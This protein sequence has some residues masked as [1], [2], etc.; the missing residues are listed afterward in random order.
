MENSTQKLD[1]PV[2]LP[3]IFGPRILPSNCCSS[4]TKTKK[5]SD[6]SGD[7]IKMMIN[8]G[9][10]RRRAMV[11]MPRPTSMSSGLKPQLR[12]YVETRTD[13]HVL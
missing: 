1:R 2:E 7:T 13:I 11:S 6:C 12:Q 10:A 5:Y 8:D 3:K 4:R 9:I